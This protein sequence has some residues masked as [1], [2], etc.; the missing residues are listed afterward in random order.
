TYDVHDRPEWAR[1]LA[2]GRSGRVLLHSGARAP[3]SPD[4]LRGAAA[5]RAPEARH[6][7]AAPVPSRA[8]AALPCRS[9]DDGLPQLRSA[10]RAEAAHPGRGARAEPGE[11]RRFAYLEG[12]HPVAVWT[13]A[14]YAA[15]IGSYDF[16][17][18]LC[19]ETRRALVRMERAAVRR[20]SLVMYASEWAARAAMRH[21][22]LDDTRVKVVPWGANLDVHPSLPEVESLVEARPL[23]P[24]RLVFCGLDWERK[25]GGLTVAIAET[26]NRRGV[27]T[28]LS[29][30]GATPPSAAT[31]PP[32]VK[33][34]GFVDMA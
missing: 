20:A 31:L 8:R 11:R 18:R 33:C 1:T 2:G 14:P 26:L 13:D 3:G 34:L 32:F 27:P 28:E 10:G 7:E 30:I 16:A 9:R 4:Q 19:G 22:G 21:Y 24:C 29:L 5:G 12:A 15:V 6:P 23:S 17:T 25:R